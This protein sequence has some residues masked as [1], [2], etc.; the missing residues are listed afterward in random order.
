MFK[1]FLK[2][3]WKNINFQIFGDNKITRKKIYK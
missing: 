1:I 3:Q 2:K